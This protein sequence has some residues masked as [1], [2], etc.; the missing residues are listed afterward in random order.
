[1]SL[2]GETNL[3]NICVPG[4]RIPFAIRAAIQEP[5]FNFTH[6][7]VEFNVVKASVFVCHGDQLNNGLSL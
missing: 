4:S 1:M 3:T 7:F 2:M 6:I 5:L